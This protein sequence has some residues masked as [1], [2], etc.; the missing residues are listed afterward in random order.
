MFK[1]SRV[2]E[3]VS[4]VLCSRYLIYPAGSIPDNYG[5]LI[6]DRFEPYCS[7]RAKKKN[8]FFGLVG[9]RVRNTLLFLDPSRTIDS[10]PDLDQGPDRIRQFLTNYRYR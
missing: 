5:L 8:L 9:S 6:S 7:I 10:A 2:S 1:A 3:F 4:D